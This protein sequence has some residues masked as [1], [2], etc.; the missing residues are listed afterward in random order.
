[1]QNS[2]LAVNKTQYIVTLLNPKFV[3]IILELLVNFLA[4]LQNKIGF[5]YNSSAIFMELN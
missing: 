1:M 4:F 5:H 2:A 3:I